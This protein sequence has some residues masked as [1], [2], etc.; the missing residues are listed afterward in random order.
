MRLKERIAVVTGSARGIGR[1]IAEA[2]V[3][4]GARVVISDRDAAAGEE[5]AR[6]L[7]SAA[8]A[9]ACDVAVPDQVERLFAE[10]VER[11]GRIDILVNNA[12]VGTP[13]LFVDTP[14]DEW[15][16][17]LRI[18]LTGAFLCGQHAVR[19]MMPQRSGRVVNIVSLSGQKGGVGRSAYGASKAG[20]AG[21]GKRVVLEA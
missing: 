20:L 7:G 6:A 3:A 12:G 18:N 9:I 17:V 4:E 8:V 16:R 2:M 19:Q 11:L 21:C 1:A 10:T 5:T 14:L 13:R 15:E